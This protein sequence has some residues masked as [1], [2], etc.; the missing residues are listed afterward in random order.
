[1]TLLVDADRAAALAD[2]SARG[3]LFLALVPP[4][5]AVVPLGLT[6]R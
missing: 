6:P 1:V 2:A 5:D 3:T 4:E